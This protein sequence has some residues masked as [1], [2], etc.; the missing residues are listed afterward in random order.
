MAYRVRQSS[1]STCT[2]LLSYGS[3]KFIELDVSLNKN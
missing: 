1:T 2:K 3:K